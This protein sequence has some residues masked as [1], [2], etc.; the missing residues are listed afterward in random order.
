MG[1]HLICH[2]PGSRR[3]FRKTGTSGK[4]GSGSGHLKGAAAPIPE[5]HLYGAFGAIALVG[6]ILMR[7]YREQWLVHTK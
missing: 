2:C 5:V 4:A 6:I 3:S 1:D 7:K